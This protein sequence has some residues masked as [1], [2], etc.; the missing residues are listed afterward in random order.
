M[1]KENPVA[2]VTDAASFIGPALT[3]LYLSEKV[4]VIAADPSFADAKAASAFQSAFP[5]V[6]TINQTSPADT[7]TR[8]KEHS[9]TFDILCTGGAYPAGKTP[10]S[11]LT[12]AATTPFF[13][14]LV[15][16]PLAYLAEVVEDMKAQGYGR[17]AFI[18]SA[19]PLGG[20]PNY[21]AY[22]SARAALNGSVKSLAVELASSG[23]SV[24]AVAPNFIATEAYFPKALIDDP[25]TSAKILS[26]V[27]AKRFGEPEEAAQSVAFFTLARSQFVTGQVLS[28]SG[29]W[30]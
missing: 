29:G 5:G 22:A 30:A 8:A 21:T 4:K 18:T 16:E 25:A 11:G 1:S 7:A 10:A 28:I 15:I 3:G 19:G 20:I 14:K 6:F 24:N 13:E 17:I 27:P 9:A 26:R 12:V 23:I 2:L